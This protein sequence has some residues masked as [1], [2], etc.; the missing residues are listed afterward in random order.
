MD[1]F[2]LRGA[3]CLSGLLLLVQ[4]E[5]GALIFLFLW[6]G[7]LLSASVCQECGG[8]LTDPS[9]DIT[10]PNYP[11]SYPP[12]SNCHWEIYA[13]SMKNIIVVFNEFNLEDT[14]DCFSGDFLSITDP[15]GDSSLFC[16][17]D[18]PWTV[19]SVGNSLVVSFVSDSDDELG[20]KF[21]LSY[22]TPSV[23]EAGWHEFGG[24]CYFFS[25]EEVTFD[26]A[27]MDCE[28]RNAQMTSIHSKQEQL[29]VQERA[30]TP[31]V[32]IGAT[33]TGMLYEDPLAFEFLDGTR[34]DYHNVWPFEAYRPGGC[35]SDCGMLLVPDRWVNRPCSISRPV[36]CESTLENGEDWFCYD[37]PFQCFHVSTEAFDFDTARSYC[38]QYPGVDILSIGD[39][40]WKQVLAG[41]SFEH[42]DFL[43]H[44]LPR[45]REFWIGL[46][47]GV[48]GDW[49]WVDGSPFDLDRWE[50]GSP[51]EEGGECAV[52]TTSSWEDLDK[53][54]FAS[55]VCKKSP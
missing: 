22:V 3:G 8:V 44:P 14:V 54:E 15:N 4:M 25:G 18:H 21:S 29:F 46:R 49:M 52:V 26:D 28:A 32:W 47:K 43:P 31:T 11:D 1:A 35:A 23:C 37:D 42:N 30:K 13:P 2:T 10:S 48:A 45:S 24:R 16:G 17:Q 36:I 50:Y 6:L 53:A 7:C 5:N 41:Q 34:N 33:T 40:E 20:L 27:R 51:A 55:Y 12:N 9:G 38:L 39:D 19:E